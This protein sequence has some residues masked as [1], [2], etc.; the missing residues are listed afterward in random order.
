[1]LLGREIKLVLS[2]IVS[3]INLLKGDEFFT[4]HMKC[5]SCGLILI[6]VWKRRPVLVSNCKFQ[7]GN[8]RN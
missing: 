4:Y 5:F 7:R 3:N 2:V 1:M 6:Q 8:E